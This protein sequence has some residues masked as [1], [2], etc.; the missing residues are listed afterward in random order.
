ML[1]KIKNENNDILDYIGQDYGK[2]LYLYLDYLKYGVDNKNVKVWLQYDKNNCIDA[3]ILMYYNGMH[4]YSKLKNCDYEEIRTLIFEQKPS[5]I[6]SEKEIIQNLEKITGYNVKYGWV[7]ELYNT[8]QILDQKEVNIAEKEK[9]FDEIA[10]LLATDFG[11][12][13]IQDIKSLSNQIKERNKEKYSRN[14]YICMDNKIVSHVATGAENKEIS[15]ITSVITDEKYRRRGLASKCMK[16]ICYD[17]I[18]E[19]KKVYLI[20]YTEAST[21]LYEKLGFKVLCEYGK[22]YLEN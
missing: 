20:N 3:V 1:K 11:L 8:N 13:S 19:G 22:L 5:I 6:C 10:R 7:K 17:L 14:Y 9:D 21:A 16:K 2:C 12:T 4:I 18:K 15:I